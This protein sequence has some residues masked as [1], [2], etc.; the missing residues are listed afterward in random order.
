MET[1]VAVASGKLEWALVVEGRFG[2]ETILVQMGG[3]GV[4]VWS[5]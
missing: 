4:S 5:S 3:A 2:E 1:L